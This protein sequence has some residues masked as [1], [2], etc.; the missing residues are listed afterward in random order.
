MNRPH[1]TAIKVYLQG[2]ECPRGS[3]TRLVTLLQWLRNEAPE[4]LIVTDPAGQPIVDP[5]HVDWTQFP[6]TDAVEAAMA[7]QHAARRIMGHPE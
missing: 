2:D 5:M 6:L 3:N 1:W 7:L 4:Q